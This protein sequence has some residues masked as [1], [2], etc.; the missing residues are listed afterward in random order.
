MVSTAGAVTTVSLETG[1]GS[2]A[3]LALVVGVVVG[4][5]GGAPAFI[6]ARVLDGGIY[7]VVDDDDDML[8]DSDGW[9]TAEPS[10]SVPKASKVG[11]GL[12]CLVGRAP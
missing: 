3:S 1:E 9:E 7:F 8:G 2:T 5:F 10:C 11:A 6:L 12:E 4:V